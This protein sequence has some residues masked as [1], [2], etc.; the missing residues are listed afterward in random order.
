MANSG[1]YIAVL[2]LVFGNFAASLSDVAVKLL[3]GNVATFQ[4]VLLRQL[5]SLALIFPLW[6]RQPPNMRRLYHPGLNV[7]RAHLI[8]IGSACMVVAITHLPLA[9]A[10]AVFYAAPLLMLPLSILLLSE[11]PSITKIATSLVGFIGVLVVLR[12]SEFHWAAVFALGTAITLALF[13]ITARKLPSRQ[14]VISTLFWTT[15]F[16]LPIASLLAISVWQPLSYQELLLIV[17]SASFILL[18]NGVA[19]TAYKKAP[20]GNIAVA[21]N[22]GLLFVTLFGIMWFNEVPDWLTVLGIIM[23]IIPLLPW[24]NLKA[25]KR[26]TKHQ[27]NKL[28][29]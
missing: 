26:Y 23:I 16:S 17:A 15:L 7:F 14:S 12:P 3:D 11:T 28:L 10:N 9:T 21:E 1:Y 25:T 4:Y 27:K 6:F 18:Y 5:F 29:K 13:N 22:S 24:N 20:A 2:L 19:V 8:L